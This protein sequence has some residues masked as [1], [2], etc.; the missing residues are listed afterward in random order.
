[1]LHRTA[2]TF[3]QRSTIAACT[4]PRRPLLSRRI[5]HRSRLQAQRLQEVAIARLQE[6]RQLQVIPNL[7]MRLRLRIQV[8]QVMPALQ[9]RTHRA[10]LLPAAAAVVVEVEVAAAA[11]QAV[12]VVAEEE[13][14][15]HLREILVVLGDPEALLAVAVEEEAKEEEEEAAKV[16]VEVEVEVEE[17]IQEEARA[18]EE[19]QIL[20]ET[21][22]VVVVDQI[23]EATREAEAP[24]E[25]EILVA[26]EAEMLEALLQPGLAVLEDGSECMNPSRHG[27]PDCSRLFHFLKDKITN[28]RR[29]A[30]SS[31][32][33]FIR[34]CTMDAFLQILRHI[35]YLVSCQPLVWK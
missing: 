21:R 10:S 28:K 16:E 22:E 7:A 35:G 18:A 6:T 33:V 13:E 5:V 31:R 23:L 29:T 14:E 8:I 30:A 26:Q 24:E 17:E 2:L 19:D 4:P 27:L 15:A 34:M 1:M 25:E 11:N 9:P 20:E 32:A 12:V 3:L